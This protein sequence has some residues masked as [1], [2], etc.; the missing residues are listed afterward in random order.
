MNFN[1]QLKSSKKHRRK[2]NEK[3][4]KVLTGTPC[5]PIKYQSISEFTESVN[6]SVSKEKSKKKDPSFLIT[7]L[8]EFNKKVKNNL[9]G[10]L[11]P[12]SPFSIYKL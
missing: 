10:S 11:K 5:Q 9:S 12:N 7:R 1:I 3:I 6:K 2:N 4:L 8:N